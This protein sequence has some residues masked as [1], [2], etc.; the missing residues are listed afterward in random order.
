MSLFI[1]PENNFQLDL[2]FSKGIC[3]SNSNIVYPIIDGI[4]ILIRNYEEHLE[5]IKELKQSMNIWY[6]FI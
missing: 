4:P 3:K 5:K 2:D 1:S 6:N